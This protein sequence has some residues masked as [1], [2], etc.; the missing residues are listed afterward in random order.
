M[1]YRD[2]VDLIVFHDEQDSDGF[3]I[4]VEDSRKTV[5]ADKKGV[6]QSEFYLAAAQGINIAKAFEM[7]SDDYN[8][9]R[10]L[11]YNGVPYYIVRTYDKN[12]ETVELTCSDKR[13]SVSG[14]V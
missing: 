14:K 2:I 3:P 6:R 4:E 13:M 11:E 1:L 7:S 5:Y 12:D 10:K 9:E 8:G